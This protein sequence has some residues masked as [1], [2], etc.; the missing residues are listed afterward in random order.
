[1]T[2]DLQRQL[3]DLGEVPRDTVPARP[4]TREDVERVAATAG[5]SIQVSFPGQPIYGH[6]G[7]LIGMTAPQTGE[8][9]SGGI[10]ITRAE[11]DRLGIADG[12]IDG[13][14]ILD[15]GPSY[16]RLPREGDQ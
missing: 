15:T 16:F 5:K 6:D 12:D 2:D 11:A 7:A 14:T 13:V 4:L 1:M 10:T 9:T 8:A 3:D